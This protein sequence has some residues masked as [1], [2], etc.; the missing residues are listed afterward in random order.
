MDLQVSIMKY[1]MFSLN[2]S[3]EDPM[4]YTEENKRI[5]SPDD[6][7]QDH[8]DKLSFKTENGQMYP[9]CTVDCSCCRPKASQS[10]F[11]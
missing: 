4:C 11:V 2:G 1:T 9:M 5:D 10:E 7:A 3:S 8:C 6:I